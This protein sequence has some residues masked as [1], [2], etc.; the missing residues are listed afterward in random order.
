MPAGGIDDAPV[1]VDVECGL[2]V[3]VAAVGAGGVD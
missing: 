1:V 2:A 3:V